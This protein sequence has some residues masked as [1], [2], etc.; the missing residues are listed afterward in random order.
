MAKLTPGEL[1]GVD[2]GIG[3]SFSPDYN[4]L[5]VLMHDGFGNAVT[6]SGS[7]SSSVRALDVSVKSMSAGDI[8][9]GAVE[10]KD[11][12]SDTRADIEADGAKNALF[13]QSNNPVS[14]YPKVQGD[15]WRVCGSGSAFSSSII[16]STPGSGSYLNLTY[17]YFSIDAIGSVGLEDTD[18]GCVSAPAHFG[19]RGGMCTSIPPETALELPENT[20]LVLTLTNTASGSTPNLSYTIAGY[21]RSS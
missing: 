16:Q 19:A 7:V 3:R 4:A 6:S 18:G 10:L 12:D 14:T 5:R 8:Q 9:I 13:I 15:K 20:G 1:Y 17:I 2:E 21:T 11:G